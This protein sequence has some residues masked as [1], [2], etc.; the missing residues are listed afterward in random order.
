MAARPRRAAIAA[1]AGAIA[2]SGC[3]SIDAV[4][5][6]P[7]ERTVQ[8]GV[9]VVLGPGAGPVYLRSVSVGAGDA[10]QVRVPTVEGDSFRVRFPAGR[11]RTAR[12]EASVNDGPWGGVSVSSADGREFAL[13]SPIELTP[14]D[15]EVIPGADGP[16]RLYEY[17][18]PQVYGRT[19]DRA[20]VTFKQK[21][22]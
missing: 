15:I 22:R 11:V 19:K 8:P 1:A 21:I 13:G 14:G 10:V 12:V 17:T 4:I 2:L 16:N 5:S 6:P 7:P 9:R 3:A 18:V 20:R